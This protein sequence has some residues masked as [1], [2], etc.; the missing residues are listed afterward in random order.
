MEV[1]L[2]LTVVAPAVIAAGLVAAAFGLAGPAAS[3][4]RRATAFPLAFLAPLGALAACIPVRGVPGLPP[5]DAGLWPI[6]VGAVGA[7]YAATPVSERWRGP[8]GW[9]AKVSVAASVFV[10]VALPLMRHT[11]STGASLGYP[12][13]ATI[14]MVGCWA[15]LER[16]ARRLSGPAV[17]LALATLAAGTATVLGTS[18][19]ALLAQCAGGVAVATGVLVLATLRGRDLPTDAVVG[20]TVVVLGGFLV[21]GMLYAEVS[22]ISAALVIAAALTVGAMPLPAPVSTGWRAAASLGVLVALFSGAAVAPAVV[23]Q[24]SPVEAESESS[25]DDD[26]G[27][28]G[29]DGY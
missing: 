28:D 10:L 7:A 15:L 20:P 5:T 3:E 22:A 24:L 1:A 6:W 11:W 9:I 17:P 4:A 26:D 23:P 25:S 12:L 2:L 8:L 29:Y 21:G 13:V 18:G 14:A 16:R 27:Y 19:T